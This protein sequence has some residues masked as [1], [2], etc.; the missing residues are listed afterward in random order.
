[1]LMLAGGLSFS[2]SGL[3]KRGETKLPMDASV[4]YQR[5]ARSSTGLVPDAST[6]RVEVRFYGRIF[7]R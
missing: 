6:V 3:N 1:M 4:R 2:H 5:I 7:G